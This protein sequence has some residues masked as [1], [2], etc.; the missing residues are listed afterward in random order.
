MAA[1]A[2]SA[3]VIGT[4]SNAGTSRTLEGA[5]VALRG[6]DREVL[7]DGLGVFR[8]ADVPAGEVTLVVSYTGLDTLNV[9]VRVTAGATVRGRRGLVS[10]VESCWVM[11]SS[12]NRVGFSPRSPRWCGAWPRRPW[13]ASPSARR[14]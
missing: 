6:T 9:P 14:P 13:G 8:L 5:R 3:V 10:G 4:V 7:T 1:A 12:W 2:E 11:A